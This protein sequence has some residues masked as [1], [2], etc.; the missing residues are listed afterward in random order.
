MSQTGKS[1]KGYRKKRPGHLQEAGSD[2]K[3]KFEPP[4]I[5]EVLEIEARAGV[6]NSP[7]TFGKDVTCDTLFS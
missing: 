5:L 3:Q 7:P 2:C 6:C 4:R 1:R